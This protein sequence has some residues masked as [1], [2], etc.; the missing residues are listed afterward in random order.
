M[1]LAPRCLFAHMRALCWPFE[2]KKYLPPRLANSAAE[3]RQF[4]IVN[5]L[6]AQKLFIARDP[7][8]CEIFLPGL[9]DSNCVRRAN[10]CTIVLN[11]RG[12]G[13]GF[14]GSPPFFGSRNEA[15]LLCEGKTL[16]RPG[17]LQAA[18]SCRSE[19]LSYLSSNCPAQIRFLR[20]L[21]VPSYCFAA[22][23]TACRYSESNS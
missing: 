8:A 3:A 14:A 22:T 12:D 6:S 5:H 16:S 1:I 19:R 11:V 10:S 15:L 4:E 7:L 21:L 23:A 13:Q 9:S 2:G 18:H 20:T 17:S